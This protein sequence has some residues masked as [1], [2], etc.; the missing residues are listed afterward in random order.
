MRPV[1]ELPTDETQESPLGEVLEF[2]RLLWAV[3]HRLKSTSKKMELTLGLTGPQRLVVRLVGQFPGIGAGRLARILHVHP[4]TLTGVLKRLVTRG[5]LERHSNPRDA[6]RALFFLTAA[7][8]AV[9]V[10]LAGTVED[11][12]DRVLSRMSRA[13]LAA[14]RDVFT[15]LAAELG[16]EQAPLD[17][18]SGPLCPEENQGLVEED[19][20]VGIESQLLAQEPDPIRLVR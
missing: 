6:R 14:A 17:A 13:Q 3:D 1:A 2:L 15:V 19:E 12:V 11:A 16:V 20:E 18:P 7:G 8:R 5:Y 9:D 10:P 4:S